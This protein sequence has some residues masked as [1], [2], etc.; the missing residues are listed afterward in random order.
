MP[1]LSLAVFAS[2]VL[3]NSSNVR[4]A[5]RPSCGF[6]CLLSRGRDWVVKKVKQGAGVIR[7]KANQ[8]AQGLDRLCQRNPTCTRARATISRELNTFYEGVKR[9]YQHFK[10]V[11]VR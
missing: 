2:G 11:A 10:R 6:G 3:Q 1:R 4:P 9:E 8:V 5:G 7:D